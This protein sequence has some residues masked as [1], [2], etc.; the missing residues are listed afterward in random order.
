MKLIVLTE[1]SAPS[2]IKGTFQ[3]PIT[4]FGIKSG[5]VYLDTDIK[6]ITPNK[7]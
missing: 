3:L 1:D 5:I 2:D 4:A 7:T 6:L